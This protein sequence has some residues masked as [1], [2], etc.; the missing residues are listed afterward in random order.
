MLPRCLIDVIAELQVI[1][2]EWVFGFDSRA[3]A[4]GIDANG[5]VVSAGVYF[6]PNRQECGPREQA[7][8][9]Y[10]QQADE[11]RRDSWEVEAVE[12]KPRST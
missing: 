12:L 11:Y 4:N 9:S 3:D 10:F 6:L 1:F 5:A 7:N 2:F 8:Q